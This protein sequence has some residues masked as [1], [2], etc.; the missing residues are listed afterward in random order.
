MGSVKGSVTG[1][2]DG[3]VIWGVEVDTRNLWEQ[4]MIRS[5]KGQ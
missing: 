1:L 5:R 4:L 3:L 2:V